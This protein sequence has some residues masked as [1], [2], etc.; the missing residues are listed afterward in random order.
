MVRDTACG[1]GYWLRSEI[2]VLVLYRGCGLKYWLWSEILV[3][4]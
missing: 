4:V 3:V 1:V 2:L